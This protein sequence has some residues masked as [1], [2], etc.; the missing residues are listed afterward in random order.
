MKFSEWLRIQ[1]TGSDYTND[2]EGNWAKLQQI[3][4]QGGGGGPLMSWD[5]R[6]YTTMWHNMLVQSLWEVEREDLVGWIE[7]FKPTKESDEIMRQCP[8]EKNFGSYREYEDAR[9]EWGKKFRPFQQ[10]VQQYRNYLQEIYDKLTNYR[11]WPDP[12]S[13][14]PF[15]QQRDNWP[16]TG[17]PS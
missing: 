9:T 11:P 5:S 4:G 1:E 6:N 14:N 2:E 17:D 8:K 12:D 3:L 10:K 15:Q 16:V 13:S 7:P